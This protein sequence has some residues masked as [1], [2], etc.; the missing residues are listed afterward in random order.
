MVFFVHIAVLYV[1]V[2]SLD[3]SV[4]IEMVVGF[5]HSTHNFLESRQPDE[6]LLTAH[7]V[8]CWMFFF[9]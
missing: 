8:V 3:H 9:Y 1:C 7:G 4:N 2:S 6:C 5:V